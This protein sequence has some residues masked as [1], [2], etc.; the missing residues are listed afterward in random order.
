MVRNL[1]SVDWASG[2]CATAGRH[3]LGAMPALEPARNQPEATLAN[4]CVGKQPGIKG[5]PDY[6]HTSRSDHYYL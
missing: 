6:D 1:V 3:P 5:G 4:R 2:W